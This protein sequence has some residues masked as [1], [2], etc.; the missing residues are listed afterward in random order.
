MFGVGTSFPPWTPSSPHPRSS[1]RKRT[2]LGR[3][4]RGG[5]SR[6]GSLAGSRGAGAEHAAA[7]SAR[8][9]PVSARFGMGWRRPRASESN[10]PGSP[11]CRIPRAGSSSPRA[12][13]LERRADRRLGHV[14]A[15][16][17]LPFL[18]EGGE[19]LLVLPLPRQ[20]DRLFSLLRVPED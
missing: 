10:P 18:E 5:G 17:E 7:W 9:S 2:T 20:G 13:G 1:A 14:R 6:L 4:W 11:R 12:E 16:R 15:D 19:V 8:R 3:T